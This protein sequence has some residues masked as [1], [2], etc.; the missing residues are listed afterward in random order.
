MTLDELMGCSRAQLSGHLAEGE[1]VHSDELVAGGAWAGV[2]LGLPRLVEAVAWKT[3][4]K[5][6]QRGRRGPCGYNV[7]VEQRGLASWQPVER[8]GRLRAYGPFVVDDTDRGVV[9]D[10]GAAA[11]RFDP[12]RWVRDPLVRVGPSLLLG[13]SDLHSRRL[14]LSARTPTWFALMPPPAPLAVDFP[15]Y[16]CLL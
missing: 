11:G 12:M 10:Y 6:V 2:A 4:L 3:F 15:P 13:V 16:R 7:A 14:G 1:P 9:L 5:V 8:R